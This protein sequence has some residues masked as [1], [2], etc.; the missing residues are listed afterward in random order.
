MDVIDRL[1]SRSGMGIRT[2]K[3]SAGGDDV[4]R[5]EV[6]DGEPATTGSCSTRHLDLD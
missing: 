2:G 1:W 6:T 3:K 4:R 5:S